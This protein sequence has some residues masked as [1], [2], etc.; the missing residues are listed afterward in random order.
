MCWWRKNNSEDDSDAREALLAEE[1]IVAKPMRKG[2]KSSKEKQYEDILN[3]YRKTS[4]PPQQSIGEQLDPVSCELADPVPESQDIV[5][6]VSRTTSY[7]QYTLS[8]KSSVKSKSNLKGSQSAPSAHVSSSSDAIKDTE[9]Q[10][11]Q[12]GLSERGD[13]L[14]DVAEKTE[15]LQQN[16]RHFR[17]V[18][19]RL[20][21]KQAQKLKK[22]KLPW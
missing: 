22:T 14:Q 15:E 7:N 4:A 17:S 6:T 20:K 1:N 8:N 12:K 5:K 16:T 18:S 3:K 10:K 13:L 19:K 11:V 21:D 9:I 2:K